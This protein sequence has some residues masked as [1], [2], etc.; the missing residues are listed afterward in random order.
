MKCPKCHYLSFEPAPRC[1]NCGFDLG[2]ADADLAIRP[3]ETP[4]EPL[5]DLELQ[6]KRRARRPPRTLGLIHPARDPEP[7]APDPLP[8]L[9]PTGDGPAV[10]PANGAQASLV[11]APISLEPG[12]AVDLA[13]RDVAAPPAAT[14]GELPLF[15]KGMSG[16]IDPPNRPSLS[17]PARPPLAVRRGAPELTR[18]RPVGHMPPRRPGPIDRDLMEDLQRVEAEEGARRRAEALAERPGDGGV[19][20]GARLAALATDWSVLAGIAGLVLWGSLRVSGAHVADLGPPALAP[21]AAFLILV[22]VTYFLL[23]TAGIGQTPGKMAFHIRVV[24]TSGAAAAG[25]PPSMRQAVYRTLLAGASGLLLGLGFL[26]AL[27]GR[28]LTLPDRMTNTRIV[29]A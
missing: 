15:V 3:A 21:L 28:G 7:A 11:P 24:D 4:D 17:E 10:A 18:P 20:R 1:R 22:D 6:P 16:G 2:M 25:H 13:R 8:S 26:P 14:P 5:A 27:I 12:I 29:R 9:V 23:F 19:S